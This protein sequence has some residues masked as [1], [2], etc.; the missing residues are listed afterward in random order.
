L[1]TADPGR[2]FAGRPERGSTPAAAPGILVPDTP[3][4]LRGGGGTRLR[5]IAR[6]GV[7]LLAGDGVDVDDIRGA[8]LGAVHTPIRIARLSEIDTTGVLTAA[9]GA[10]PGQVWVI[11]PD[12]YVAAV[13][14]TVDGLVAALRR[15]HG[16]EPAAVTAGSRAAVRD[17]DRVFATAGR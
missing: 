6:H 15:L 14:D 11:R 8:A 1:T 13:T 2:P 4:T 9:L 12:A 10:A 16:S 7:L 5:E 3:V 17:S